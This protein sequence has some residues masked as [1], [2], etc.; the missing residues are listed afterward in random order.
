MDDINAGRERAENP[1]VVL[2]YIAHVIGVVIRAIRLR[3]DRTNRNAAGC[4]KR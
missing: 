1:L 4:G 2:I 3:F